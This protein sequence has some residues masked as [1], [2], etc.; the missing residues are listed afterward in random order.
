MPSPFPGMDPYLEE[1]SVWPGFHHRLITHTAHILQKPLNERGYFADIGERVWLVDPQRHIYPDVTVSGLSWAGSAP[2]TTPDSAAEGLVAVADEPVMV[3]RDLVEVTEPFVEV[4]DTTTRNVVTGIEFVSPT[5]KLTKDGRG[6]Y[7]QKQRE[8][9][10]SG[11][12]LVEVD[13]IRRGRRVA[14]VPESI[15]KGQ[16]RHDYLVSLSRHP[17]VHY[18]LYP[19]RLRDRLPRIK[20]PLKHG[21]RDEILDLQQVMTLAYEDGPYSVRVDYSLPCDPPLKSDDARW[22]NELLI[23]KGLRG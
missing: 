2:E 13:F 7:R 3:L 6:L 16:A 8:L 1:P 9:L 19:I 10:R 5:N 15:L 14:D 20:I 22:A 4:F 21:E 11:I 17:A 23:E 18:E 12:N